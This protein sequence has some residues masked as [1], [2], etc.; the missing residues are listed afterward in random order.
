MGRGGTAA[1]AV[2]FVISRIPAPM[3]D[4]RNIPNW[5]LLA[6]SALAIVML[7]TCATIPVPLLVG[8]RR[9]L[10]KIAVG[11]RRWRTVWTV[12]GSLAIAVEA[13][14]LF[15]LTRFL[16]TP[17]V[18]LAQPSWHALDFSLVFAA[19]GGLMALVLLAAS[20][21]TGQASPASPGS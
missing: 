19:T 4:G 3:P 14:F 11:Q 8:G 20:R 7:P 5:L 17:Y 16:L 12:A 6:A 10:T 15:R 9:Q 21:S 2:I 1:C 18:N 13:V